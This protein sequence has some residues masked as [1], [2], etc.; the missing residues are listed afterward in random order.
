MNELIIKYCDINYPEEMQ[1]VA[2]SMINYY[3][4]RNKADKTKEDLDCQEAIY[5]G[6]IKL[7]RELARLLSNELELDENDIFETLFM[8]HIKT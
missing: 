4:I 5:V 2:H 7:F 1:L 8:I 6:V 3:S